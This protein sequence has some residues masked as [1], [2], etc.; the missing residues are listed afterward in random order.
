MGVNDPFL[1][2]V[3]LE[4]RRSRIPLADLRRPLEV[5]RLRADV[6]QRPIIEGCY[7][8][9]KVTEFLQ[10]HAVNACRRLSHY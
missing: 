2:L 9:P 6:A 5:G 7:T 10:N 1:P 8:D 4:T 3:G